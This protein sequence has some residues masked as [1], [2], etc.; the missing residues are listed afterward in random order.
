[1]DKTADKKWKCLFLV[2][3]VAFVIA[4]VFA[5]S[6]AFSDQTGRIVEF[7]KALGVGFFALAVVC[8]VAS[9]FGSWFFHDKD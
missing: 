1:M 7:K 5:G 8:F 3:I 2:S 6:W 9:K 4:V